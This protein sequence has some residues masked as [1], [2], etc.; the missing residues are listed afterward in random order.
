MTMTLSTARWASNGLVPLPVMVATADNVT[1]T[2]NVW[3]DSWPVIRRLHFEV[4]AFRATKCDSGEN[5]DFVALKREALK[6]DIST[7][8]E[9][10]ARNVVEKTLDRGRKSCPRRRRI[11]LEGLACNSENE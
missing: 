7:T 5:L 11:R 2:G 10:N 3:V 9:R 4:F 1:G 6:V 8:F